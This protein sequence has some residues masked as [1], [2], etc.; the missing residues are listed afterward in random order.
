[1]VN[2]FVPLVT[3]TVPVL[4]TLAQLIGKALGWAGAGLFWTEGREW[5][6]VDR[7]SYESK[8]GG[9]NFRTYELRLWGLE[10]SFTR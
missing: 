9:Q 3:R 2:E 7:W 4:D 8:L 10:A 6:Y 5:S 1:M